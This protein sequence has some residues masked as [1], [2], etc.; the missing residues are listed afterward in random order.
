MAYLILK[1]T[2][3]YSLKV[4][5]VY[6]P[7]STY[8]D[9]E[10]EAMYEDITRAIETNKTYF[11]VVMGDFNAKVGTQREDETK[12]GQH[13]EGLRNH[14]GQMLVNFLEQQDLFLMNSFFKKSPNRKW[15]WKSP[16]GR[17]ANE[18][19]YI[20][21]DKRRIFRDVTVLNRCDTGS[22]HRLVRSTL[23]INYKLE[24]SRLLRA[25]LRPSQIEDP[26]GF[27]LELQNRFSMLGNTDNVDEM[28][29]RKSV[30]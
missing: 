7:T 18:I 17:T 15:T 24:R 1:L 30:V 14:R 3:R 11:T 9:D 26:E 21:T 25:Q 12:I 4:I 16:D 27:Q 28:K 22:D 10:V 5:Q 2:E 13:G 8:A 19:D 20:L 23:D 6:A 29:D